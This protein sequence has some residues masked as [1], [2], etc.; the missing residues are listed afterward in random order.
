MLAS[1]RLLVGIASDHLTTLLLLSTISV[2]AQGLFLDFELTVE[3]VRRV[4]FEHLLLHHVVVLIVFCVELAHSP[5][6][7]IR[8]LLLGSW[9]LT[10]LLVK[11]D[12][13]RIF[14]AL[15]RLRRWDQTSSEGVSL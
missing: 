15:L 5:V 12:V 7:D 2:F 4:L 3:I 11:V 14:L 13:S 9:T 8:F 1:T 6:R 10:E